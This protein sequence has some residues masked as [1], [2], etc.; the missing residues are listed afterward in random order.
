MLNVLFCVSF[1]FLFPYRLK[2]HKKLLTAQGRKKRNV[3]DNGSGYS[4]GA[5]DS[6]G[7]SRADGANG[8]R[9]VLEP[10]TS[11]LLL[12]RESVRKE[13]VQIITQENK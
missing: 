10:S 6:E 2:L 8:S 7:T 4:A 5:T 12:L 1:A 3:S 9:R 11:D 13:H